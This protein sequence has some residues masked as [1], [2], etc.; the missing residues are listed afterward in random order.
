M[1]NF[2][3]IGILVLVLSGCSKEPDL[4][5]QWEK[6]IAVEAT[7]IVGHEVRNIRLKHLENGEYSPEATPISDAQVELIVAGTEHT[8]TYNSEGE[9]YEKEGLLVE[10]STTYQLRVEYRDKTLTSSTTTP[11]DLHLKT[12][13]E[14][15]YSINPNYPDT[16]LM[17]VWWND[18]PTNRYVLHLKSLEQDPD[19]ILFPT[20]FPSFNESHLEPIEEN[21]FT[22][23]VSELEYYGWHQLEVAA[24][25]EKY[26]EVYDYSSQV[27]QNIIEQGPSNIENGYGF[28]TGISKGYLKFYVMQ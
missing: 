17:T 1:K 7:L 20:D 25:N 3:I 18:I 26:T 2:A 5:D 8:L 4:H 14:P 16:S 19:P 13:S 27:N 11:P 10:P 22:M 23:K 21:T 12:N 6:A 28:F 24:V 15:F 9:A